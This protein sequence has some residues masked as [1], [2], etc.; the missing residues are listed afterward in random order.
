MAIRS[1]LSLAQQLANIRCCGP[2]RIVPD[3][4]HRSI[5][6]LSSLRQSGNTDDTV[7]P[8]AKLLPAPPAP[9]VDYI[10]LLGDD[11]AKE[12]RAAASAAKD[13]RDYLTVSFLSLISSSTGSGSVA[14][15]GVLGLSS[16]VPGLKSSALFPFLDSAK[17]MPCSLFLPGSS[18]SGPVDKGG[19]ASGDR[20]SRGTD[21]KLGA[22]NSDDRNNSPVVVKGSDSNTGVRKRTSDDRKSSAETVKG[23]DCCKPAL[24]NSGKK[25]DFSEAVKGLDCKS[26]ARHS[27]GKMNWFSRWVNSCSDDTKSVLA[28]VTVP[29]VYGACLGEPRSIPTRSMYP[30]FDVG[31][32]I[33]AEKV[34]YLFK[35]PEVTD[36]VIFKAPQSLQDIGYS[37]TDVFIKRVV[38]KAGD[39]VEVR[40]GKLLV[41]GFIQDEDFILEP[42]SYEME[43]V[44]VPEGYVFV[45]GDNRN[46]SFDSHDWGPLP[47]KNIVGRSVLR[48]WPPSKISN[49]VYESIQVQNVL[50]VA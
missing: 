21:L 42:L 7:R 33:L 23:L 35:E 30:T 13:C 11:P 40:D 20:S 15:L 12:R 47:V 24:A 14:G 39:Y 27:G 19:T 8:R 43:P 48:Y 34:S 1:F 29:L 22:R 36:I 45:L 16:S 46:N 32:R 31:D 6:A 28:A 2:C 25:S 44:L 17:W 3:P 50:G 18:R 38:A 37:P 10:T 9:L 4:T 49:T 41:N 26:E 5:A